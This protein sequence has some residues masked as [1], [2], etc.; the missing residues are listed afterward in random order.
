[1]RVALLTTSNSDSENSLLSPQ[2]YVATAFAPF[3]DI[4]IVNAPD[5]SHALD[6]LLEQKPSV[7]VLP[8]VGHLPEEM[9][10]KL[11]QWMNDGGTILRF[12][13]SRLSNAQSQNNG[14][15]AQRDP[16]LPVTLRS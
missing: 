15:S 1:R 3:A 2:R 6:Q 4:I 9:T 13:S 12:A 10:N 5:I 14:L 8:D 11:L 16:L 7:L